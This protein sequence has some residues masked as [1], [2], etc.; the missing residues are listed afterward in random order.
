LTRVVIS[1]SRPDAEHAVSAVIPTTTA[2]AIQRV[3]FRLMAGTFRSPFLQFPCR[4]A[5]FVGRA[6]SD[7]L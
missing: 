3:A 6:A 7:I 5:P 1:V 2:T 4:R